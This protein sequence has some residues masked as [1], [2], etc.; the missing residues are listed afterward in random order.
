MLNCFQSSRLAQ[1]IKSFYWV[2][3]CWELLFGFI[4]QFRLTFGH[5]NILG[6]SLERGLHMLGYFIW[7]FQN[8]R[9]ECA[10]QLTFI[11]I[12]FGSVGITLFGIVFA[13]ISEIIS[14]GIGLF[15]VEKLKRV[16]IMISLLMAVIRLRV[17]PYPLFYLINEKLLFLHIRCI[18]L[19][20]HVWGGQNVLLVLDISLDFTLCYCFN[21]RLALVISRYFVW[22]LGRIFSSWLFCLR[23]CLR[24]S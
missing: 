4:G 12:V 21:M 15:L 19:F 2:F 24:F 6:K 22:V 10:L 9:F 17:E 18:V 16:L 23:F 13:L 20:L 7:F 3:L 8:A 5:T 11:G 1:L 14:I